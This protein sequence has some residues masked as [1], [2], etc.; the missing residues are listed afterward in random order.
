MS[1][2]NPLNAASYYAGV[3]NAS[4]GI[5][6]K[7]EKVE[8]DKKIRFSQLFNASKTEQEP[9]ETTEINLPPQIRTMS[10]EEAAVFLKDAVDLA[11]NE[12]SSNIN[13]ENIRNFKEKVQQF[14]YYVVIHNFQINSKKFKAT[15]ISHGSFSNYQLPPH[16]KDPRTQVEA[17]NQKLDELTKMTLQNQ[18]NNLKILAQV[19]E[20]K[21][22]IV[23]L[24]QT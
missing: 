23:D 17:I 14:V 18:M 20:I 12:L 15:E 24:I 3:Q 7:N 6:K 1:D 8:S 5:P 16:K 10:L 19:D 4:A 13:N 2:I 11:G 9:S 21:G 22:L